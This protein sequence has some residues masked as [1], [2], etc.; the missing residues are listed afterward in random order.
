MAID[1]FYLT[2]NRKKLTAEHQKRVEAA[3]ADELRGE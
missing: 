3:L 1:A 2:S